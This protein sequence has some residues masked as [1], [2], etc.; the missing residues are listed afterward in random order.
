MLYAKLEQQRAAQQMR[1][2]LQ[3]Q[4]HAQQLQQ[5]GQQHGNVYGIQQSQ[6]QHMQP[7]SIDQSQIA[8][9]LNSQLQTQP[10]QQLNTQQPTGG[11]TGTLDFFQSF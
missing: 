9:S 5:Q 6:Q 10:V 4:Q 1:Q 2:Q 8:R 3:Q 11:N 7:S